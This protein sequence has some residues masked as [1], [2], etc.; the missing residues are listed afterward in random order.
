MVAVRSMPMGG[1][2]AP[3][4][5][6]M[7]GIMGPPSGQAPVMPM[8]PQGAMMQPMVQP[9]PQPQQ[10]QL[11]S[12][13]T[14]YGGSVAGRARF[15]EGLRARKGAFMGGMQERVNFAQ[16]GGMPMGVPRVSNRGMSIPMAGPSLGRMIGGSS[17]VSSA[18]LQLPI[19]MLGGGVVPLFRGLGR[20]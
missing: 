1:V 14:T 10:Q 20:Y 7:G 16:I 12:G 15:R 17:G 9:Q 3:M 2:P 8:G 18:P 4:G 5:P 13:S 6:P 11:S 19:G